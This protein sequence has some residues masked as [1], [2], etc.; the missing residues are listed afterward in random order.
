M[1]RRPDLRIPTVTYRGVTI[2]LYRHRNRWKSTFLLHGHPRFECYGPSQRAAQDS[3]EAA[4]AKNLDP[5]AF[6][7]GKDEQAAR[8]LLNDHGVSLVEAARYWLTKHSKP[9][10]EGT[11]N[12]V[13]E[14]WLEARQRKNKSYHHLKS[15]R[16]RTLHLEEAFDNRQLSSLSLIELA[17]WQDSLES[18][19]EGRTAR[20]IHDSCKQMFKF[21]RK[22]GYLENDRITAMEELDRPSAGP[23]KKEIF[24]PEQ[25]QKLLNAAWALGSPAAATLVIAGFTAIRSEELYTVDPD[26]PEDDQLM[27]EDF[28]WDQKFIYV[29]DS[30]AKLKTAR[31]VPVPATALSLLKALKGT[32]QVYKETR[33][34][35]AYARIARKAGITWKHNALRHSALSYAMLLTNSPA[36]VANWAGNSVAIIEASYR[37]RGATKPQAKE[38]FK[39]LP[40]VPWDSK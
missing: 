8:T 38:W 18:K 14:I 12:Q 23:S 39:L 31:N 33:L 1:A 40:Q 7:D 20:N 35:A 24:T 5:D 11:V 13:R 9:L 15:L 30:V 36:E 26:A 17:N 10:V 4:I 28:R 3:A 6:A 19:Y 21:A 29:R 34:D 2:R 22:R 25:M 16:G 32:G 27:W 37:N